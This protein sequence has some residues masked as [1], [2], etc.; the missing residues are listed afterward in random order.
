MKK[1]ERLPWSRKIQISEY[2][3]S[4]SQKNEYRRPHPLRRT[5]NDAGAYEQ[6]RTNEVKPKTERQ[7]CKALP[8]T[9]KEMR[10]RERENQWNRR[11]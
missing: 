1:R 2:P 11:G 4:E 9:E 7:P 6:N 10:E 5:E 8:M 3:P